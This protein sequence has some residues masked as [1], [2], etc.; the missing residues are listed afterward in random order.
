MILSKR[1]R[2]QRE[3]RELKAQLASNEAHPWIRNSLSEA[4]RAEWDEVTVKS[5]EAIIEAE[6][7]LA[8]PNAFTDENG[9]DMEIHLTPGQRVALGIGE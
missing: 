9:R 1:E 3:I 8:D 5:K 6:R 7:Y 2:L 4:E